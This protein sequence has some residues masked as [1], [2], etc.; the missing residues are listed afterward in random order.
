MPTT[1]LRTQTVTLHDFCH[2]HVPLTHFK[3]LKYFSILRKS[4]NMW[5]NHQKQCGDFQ[6]MVLHG[7]SLKVIILALTTRKRV[8][9]KSITLLRSI[10]ELRLQGRSTPPKLQIQA[11]TENHSLLWTEANS[12]GSTSRNQLINNSWR[13]SANRSQSLKL[14]GSQS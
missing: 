7:K 10:R 3:F 13:L 1:L 2:I 9:E 11:N 8:E 14:Q 4:S 12:R 6:L 5:N